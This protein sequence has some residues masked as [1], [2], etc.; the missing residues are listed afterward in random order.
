MTLEWKLIKWQKLWIKVWQHSPIVTSPTLW[1]KPCCLS[2][3]PLG[4]VALSAELQPGFEGLVIGG[5][6]Q[7]MVGVGRGW[8]KNIYIRGAQKSTRKQA[9]RCMSQS[10]QWKQTY[11]L[12]ILLFLFPFIMEDLH[13]QRW[14]DTDMSVQLSL[15]KTII[16]L[17]NQTVTLILK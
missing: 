14:E 10:I 3:T 6:K 9:I 8:R 7:G 2:S 4:G 11:L 12:F 16:H 13:H 5:E 1:G 15:P 17:Q